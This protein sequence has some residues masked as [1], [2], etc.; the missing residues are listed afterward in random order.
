MSMKQTSNRRQEKRLS[1]P[2][3]R[4]QVR[5]HSLV[6]GKPFEEC[7]LVDLSLNGLAF[8]SN[9][10][11][12]EPLQKLDFYL[13]IE[14]QS[15]T[16]QALV[17]YNEKH[18]QTIQYGLL[19]I[20]TTPE[21]SEVLDNLECSSREAKLLAAR[22]AERLVFDLDNNDQDQQLRTKLQ[23][24]FDSVLAFSQR[25]SELGVKLRNAEQCPV[26]PMEAIYLDITTGECFFPLF[27]DELN[28]TIQASI[29]ATYLDGI[30][31][32][33]YITSTGEVFN[34]IVEVLSFLSDH[35]SVVSI[36]PE[37]I[38]T[39]TKYPPQ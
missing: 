14:N 13:E 32:I 15:V 28:Q 24:L 12:F 38:S 1:L 9:I 7:S 8:D 4:I 18:S 19:F 3:T 21:I 22:M 36:Q 30:N 23:L 6:P 10:L 20:Q 34:N 25:L 35:L 31:K 5:K 39:L 16:G 27:N 17:C 37:R 33:A 2:T 26:T 29:T 11:N